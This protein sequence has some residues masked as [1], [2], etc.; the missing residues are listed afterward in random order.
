MFTKSLNIKQAYAYY[1]TVKYKGKKT[2]PF[3]IELYGHL[4]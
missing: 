2:K 3:S 1:T 4:L